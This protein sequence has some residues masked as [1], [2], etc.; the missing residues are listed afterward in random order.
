MSVD[1]QCM[2]EAWLTRNRTVTVDPFVQ[3]PSQS[4]V[5]MP[6]ITDLRSE[7]GCMK[8]LFVCSVNNTVG[9]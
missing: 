4:L 9:Q 6:V 3:V 5:C 8:V 7:C 2:M 1:D